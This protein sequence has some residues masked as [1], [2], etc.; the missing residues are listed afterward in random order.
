M[1][2]FLFILLICTNS[3]EL[4]T[5]KTDFLQE[6]KE[7]ALLQIKIDDFVTKENSI[8]VL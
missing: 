5:L 8:E 4:Q 7:K 1:F 6:R 2:Y 3:E